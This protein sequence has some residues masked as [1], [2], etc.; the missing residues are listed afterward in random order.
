ML[1]I[2]TQQYIWG[3]IDIT[4]WGLHLISLLRE[5]G[6]ENCETTR[7]NLLCIAVT[8]QPHMANLLTLFANSRR[9]DEL[10]LRN[11]LPESWHSSQPRRFQWV[12]IGPANLRLIQLPRRITLQISYLWRTQTLCESFEPLETFKVYCRRQENTTIILSPSPTPYDADPHRFY[13]QQLNHASQSSFAAP[14]Q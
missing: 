5:H 3:S 2:V 9:H 6:T 12:P 4:S 1:T 7:L 11:C 14:T 10:S 8:S 13:P